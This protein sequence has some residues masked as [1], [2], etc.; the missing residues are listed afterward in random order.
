MGDKNEAFDYEALKKKT[1]EQLR[2][3]KS[4]FGKDGAF[5]PLLKEFLE[6]ALDAEMDAHLSDEDTT[7]PP[8]NRRNGHNKK[9]LKTGEGSFELE[10]PRDRNSNFEPQIIRKRETILAESL[11]Q[12]IIGMYGL[13]MS[14]RD[15]ATHIKEMYD[16]DISASTLS[17]ITDKIIPLVIEWQARPLDRLYCIVWMD[18]MYYK[19]K[20]EGKVVTRCVYNILGIDAEGRKDILG[21][22][23]SESE[24][25]NFWLSV[26]T[27]LQNRGVADILIAC[28]DNLKGFAEAIE[29]VF[30]KT[31]VQ[32]CIVHQ[33]RNSLKYVAAR[34]Q[35]VFIQ[36]LKS[37][38]QAVS[39]QAA[40]LE[41]EKLSDKWHQKYPLVI[42]SWQRNWEKLST[43][44][45][46]PEAIRKLIYTTNTI[47]GYHRQ[48]RKVTKTKGAFTSD[49]ALLKL[50]YLATQ[51]VQKKWIMPLLNWG[52]TISQL[53]IIFSDR[54]K[55][56]I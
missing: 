53:S 5:A 20:Q 51:N 27:D 19:V 54:L 16:T 56:K 4:L 46:Y 15:I 32:S 11:E 6:S 34:D 3:G 50:V 52:I 42:N 48:I 24:G 18:A 39:K 2:S 36:D 47:E 43:F 44:F 25:A 23:V 49:M 55:L 7:L 28:T 13:G 29:T 33:I 21:C 45:K 17:A 8:G 30:T 37:V 40:E 35:K 38:Y 22:Y 31:D 10:T 9:L 26:L 14:L 1:L 12:K 41:L